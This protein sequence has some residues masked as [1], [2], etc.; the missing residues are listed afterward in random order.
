MYKQLYVLSACNNL[1][2]YNYFLYVFVYGII[3][4][5]NGDFLLS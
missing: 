5:V 2:I 1:M 3:N 4:N